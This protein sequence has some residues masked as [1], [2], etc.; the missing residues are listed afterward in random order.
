MTAPTATGQ[1]PIGS[2]FQVHTEIAGDQNYPRIAMNPSGNF[3][4]VY[5]STDSIF[6]QRFDAS[7]AVVGGEFKV[8]T[9]MTY[10]PKGFPSV[11]M[12][13]TSNFVVVWQSF[14][15][16]GNLWGVYGQR[17]DNAGAKV[18]S[19]FLVNTYTTSMQFYPKVAMSPTG[20]FVVVWISDGQDTGGYG[21]YGQRYDNAGAMAGSEFRV[22]TTVA[23]AQTYPDVAMNA[24]GKFVVVWRED[25]LD[26][27]GYGIY[28]QRYDASGTP[29][30]T[31]TQVNTYTI[32]HQREPSL[33]ALPSGGH[34]VVWMSAGPDGD[35]FGVSGQRYDGTGATVG[36]E[37]VVNTSPTGNQINPRVSYDQFG[38]FTVVWD[39]YHGSDSDG[40]M[41]QRF[42]SD[43]TKTG[44]EYRVNTYTVNEQ[45]YADVAVSAVHEVIVWRS[46]VQD[47]DDGGIYAQRFGS[48]PLLEDLTISGFSSTAI[49]S[50]A[51]L[52]AYATYT[53][54][55]AYQD[56][57]SF[58]TSVYVSTDDEIT[59]GDY[60][61]STVILPGLLAG[62]DT[63]L[64]V[65]FP[66]PPD[67]P[68][69]DIYLGLFV[70][71]LEQVTEFSE[72]NNTQA[73][74]F[75][76]QVPLIDSVK[77]VLGDQGGWVFL[78]WYASPADLPAGGGLI[79]EYTL[80]RTIDMYGASPPLVDT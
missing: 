73:N 38:G 2:E 34:V 40:V 58:R 55:A 71:D 22:N 43:G 18:G 42:L 8:N 23:N 77:D 31:E 78:K 62:D 28:Q 63:T 14:L 70:D 66:L 75:W 52:P 47:G 7:G 79:T 39:G 35:G 4:V 65:S 59:A 20:E 60:L 30:G 49:L 56:V 27:D 6:G 3:V 11:A 36:T 17:Y 67:A 37:F 48:S 10:H 21:V 12:D 29:L 50:D 80:W 15:Q 46:F 19:E 69:G 45:E 24:D 33:A 41:A 25:V 9:D 26:G 76:Y 44:G 51:K 32:D 64:S 68:R 16:D 53:V 13:S 5:S 54:A 61:V 57:D 74:P 72:I 1:T